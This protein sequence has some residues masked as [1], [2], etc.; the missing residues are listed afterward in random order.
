[1]YTPIYTIY[2]PIYSIYPIY[3]IRYE[4]ELKFESQP[5][6]S[7]YSNN[8]MDLMRLEDKI[9]NKKGAQPNPFGTVEAITDKV[10]ETLRYE[11]KV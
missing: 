5:R 10:N 7:R 9:I 8:L 3:P 11:T 4:M 1:M 2:T 6:S